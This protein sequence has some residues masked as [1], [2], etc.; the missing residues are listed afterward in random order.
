MSRLTKQLREKMLS[1]VL[2]HAFSEKQSQAKSELNVAAEALYMAHHGEHLATLELLPS[3]FIYRSKGFDVSIGGQ[4]HMIYFD[5]NRIMTYESNHSRVAF[6]AD[7][8][9]AQAFLRATDKVDDVNKERRDMCREVNAVLESV[10]TF[11]K[12]W[13]VWPECKSLLEKFEDKPAIAI[14]PA[15]QVH[16]LNAAL[17]LPVDEVPA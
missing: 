12:L 16:R 6:E 13:E 3:S 17:G 1:T 8:P 9:E 11:K 2:D 5:E 15:V 10:H 7:H 4:R 14:L